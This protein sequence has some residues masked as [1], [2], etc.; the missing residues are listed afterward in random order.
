MFNS[1]SGRNSATPHLCAAQ[2][3][4]K[5]HCAKCFSLLGL[6]SKALV[7]TLLIIAPLPAQAAPKA[8]LNPQAAKIQNQKRNKRLI[9][10]QKKPRILKKINQRITKEFK[11]SP[12]KRAFFCSST[13]TRTWNQA[14][15]SRSLY[16]LSYRG[17]K[18][19]D[20][21]RKALSMSRIPRFQRGKFT[22]LDIDIA[23]RYT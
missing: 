14:V 12:R 11:K 19:C 10:A 15:N 1:R 18:W 20:Y 17:I 4:L 2:S 3:V 8:N 13:R 5:S 16:Q 21:N 23:V 7:S 6:F 22:S 9:L